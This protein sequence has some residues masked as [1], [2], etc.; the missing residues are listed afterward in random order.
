ML[1]EYYRQTGF[2]YIGDAANWS[3][4]WQNTFD[5][6][7]SLRLVAGSTWERQ[8]GNDNSFPESGKR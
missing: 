6:S 8:E 3:L 4:D 7:D 2:I 5:V 1:D